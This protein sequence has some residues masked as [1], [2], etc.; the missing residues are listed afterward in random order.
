MVFRDVVPFLFPGD[1]FGGIVLS[2]SRAE[3]GAR[4]RIGFQPWEL[5]EQMSRIPHR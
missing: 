4:G 1:R 5:R 2:G 3:H